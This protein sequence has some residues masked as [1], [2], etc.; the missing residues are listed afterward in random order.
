MRKGTVPLTFGIHRRIQ[1]IG[2]SLSGVDSEQFQGE[3]EQFPS[4]L[5]CPD[6]RKSSVFPSVVCIVNNRLHLHSLSIY[7]ASA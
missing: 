1:T 3:G 4:P 6:K 2:V 5:E 7:P